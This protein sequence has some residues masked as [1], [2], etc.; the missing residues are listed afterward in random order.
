MIKIT[1]EG[2]AKRIYDETRGQYTHKYVVV[3]EES[4]K[5]PNV[6]RFKMKTANDLVFREGARIRVAAYLDGREW[7]N[8]Q[9][10]TMYFT[11]LT[12]DTIEVLGATS[13]PAPSNTTIAA[14]PTSATGWAPLLALGA[15]YGEDQASVTNYCKATHPGKPSAS[16]TVADWQAV[17]DAIVKAHAPVATAQPS[18]AFEDE[19]PF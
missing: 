3:S 5:Y 6:L 14:K 2:V 8:P 16:Y 11:D 12:V 17:A 7:T 10:Q 13:E 15:A 1:F 4:S 9:G 18:S 19:M